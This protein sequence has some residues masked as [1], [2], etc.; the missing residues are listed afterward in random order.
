M[1]TIQQIF[2]RVGIIGNRKKWFNSSYGDKIG[3][4]NTSKLIG[5]RITKSFLNKNKIN[6]LTDEQIVLFL[7]EIIEKEFEGEKKD[8]CYLILTSTGIYQHYDNSNQLA[9]IQI[10][11]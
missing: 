9:K 5:I 6:G 10:F 7:K 4:I 8:N 1:T 11:K 2:D 3:F